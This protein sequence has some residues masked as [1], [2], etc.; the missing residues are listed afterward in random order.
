MGGHSLLALRLANRIRQT[1]GI[2][3]SMRELIEAQTVARLLRAA[4]NDARKSVQPALK[5]RTNQGELL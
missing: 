5:R 3:I 4:G 2:D 1:L